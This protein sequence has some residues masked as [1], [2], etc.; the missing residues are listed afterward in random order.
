MTTHYDCR[1]V[2][3]VAVCVD[4]VVVRWLRGCD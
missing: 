3:V 4:P 2:R 1:V